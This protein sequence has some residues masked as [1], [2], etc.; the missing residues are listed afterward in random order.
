MR[1]TDIENVFIGFI[2]FP[3]V[4]NFY[5]EINLENT[6]CLFII[7]II[8]LITFIFINSEKNTGVKQ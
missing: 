4:E 3:F 8:S 1:L 6:F 2:L 5:N 7:L